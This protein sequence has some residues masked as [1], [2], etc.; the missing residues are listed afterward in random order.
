MKTKLYIISLILTFIFRPLHAEI[1]IAPMTEWEQNNFSNKWTNESGLIYSN[2]AWGENYYNSGYQDFSKS[3]VNILV[4]CVCKWFYARPDRKR[5]WCFILPITNLNAEKGHSYFSRSNPKQKQLACQI[6][7][8]IKIGFKADGQNKD[9]VIWL[10]RSNPEYDSYSG[11][12]TYDSESYIE[13]CVGNGKWAKSNCQY[14]SCAQ[15]DSPTLGIQSDPKGVMYIFWGSLELTKIY[16]YMEE[17]CYIQIGVGT[18]AQIQIGKASASAPGALPP[19]INNIARTS[20]L[21]Q[22]GNVLEA[23]S[24]LYN[25][26]NFYY[27]NEAYNLACCYAMLKE[28]DKCMEI[29]NALIKYNG[30]TLAATYNIRGFVNEYRGNKLDALDD[31]QKAND[32]ENYARL[33]NEIYRPKPVQQKQQTKQTRQHQNNSTYKPALTK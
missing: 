15:G 17:L 32:Q 19:T 18:Q 30:E 12:E 23:K 6:Y 3:G 26:N 1:I 13:Y 14:P 25:N 7:W 24:K 9:V 11:Y 27:E 33:Y 8:Y 31:F 4:K 21:I 22:Q 10:K 2:T 28:Y 16:S 29:C 5:Y 20:E